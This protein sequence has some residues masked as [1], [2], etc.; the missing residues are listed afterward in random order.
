MILNIVQ[1]KLFEEFFSFT[2][3]SE[4]MGIKAFNELILQHGI[5]GNKIIDY[6]R[7][8]DIGQNNCLNFK[9]YVLGKNISNRI[10]FINIIY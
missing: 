5:D 2:Y 7:A 6:F 4:Y 8:F 1:E 3:P 10:N 9:D